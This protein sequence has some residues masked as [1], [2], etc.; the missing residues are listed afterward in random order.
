MKQ[1]PT[2]TLYY[3][4]EIQKGREK[5]TYAPEIAMQTPFLCT[6]R[7]V[8]QDDTEAGSQVSG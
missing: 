5:R 3:T 4:T 6:A 2:Q 1:S 8:S 7:A